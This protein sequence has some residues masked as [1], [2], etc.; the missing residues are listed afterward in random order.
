MLSVQVLR[1]EEGRMLRA[2]HQENVAYLR[3]ELLEAG[4]PVIYCPSHIIP[5][6]VRLN[7]SSYFTRNTLYIYSI[8]W[9]KP[10]HYAIRGQ[11]RLFS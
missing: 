7:Q 10:N 5:I 2:Q 8:G 6:H 11:K 4:L 9:E 3:R 1:G